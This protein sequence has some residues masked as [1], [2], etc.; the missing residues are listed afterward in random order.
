MSSLA[1]VLGE[2]AYCI[3]WDQNTQSLSNKS[4]M[5]DVKLGGA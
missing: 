5:R 3:L 4:R 2:V 1:E